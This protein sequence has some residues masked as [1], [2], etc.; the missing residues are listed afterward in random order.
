MNLIFL[1]LNLYDCFANVETVVLD[2]FYLNN[3]DEVLEIL[4]KELGN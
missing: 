4:K 1:F 2:S 3:R